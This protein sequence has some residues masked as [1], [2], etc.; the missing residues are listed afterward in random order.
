MD[1]HIIYVK[2]FPD[3]TGVSIVAAGMSQC[4]EGIPEPARE[5]LFMC[6]QSPYLTGNGRQIRKPGDTYKYRD[7]IKKSRLLMG[8]II[9]FSQT[10]I[11]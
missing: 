1:K 2:I 7:L 11:P 5:R 10:A 4:Q 8:D 9:G 3:L 6:G